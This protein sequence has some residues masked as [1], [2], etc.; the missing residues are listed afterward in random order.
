MLRGYEARVFL[1]AFP[2]R[3]VA[4]GPLTNVVDATAAAE[5]IC[6]GG[7]LRSRGRWPPVWPHEF[8]FTKDRERFRLRR[9]TRH[10]RNGRELGAAADQRRDRVRVIHVPACGAHRVIAVD[11]Q[12]SVLTD[13]APKLARTGRDV[14]IRCT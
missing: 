14:S 5:V 6:V 1:R 8:N 10:G 7:T 13:A 11:E 12:H 3:I 2:D 4:L 9:V